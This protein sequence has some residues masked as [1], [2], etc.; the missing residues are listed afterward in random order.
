[1]WLPVYELQPLQIW[2]REWLWTNAL[3]S[4][5]N[6][7]E[8]LCGANP[9]EHGNAVGLWGIGNSC[10]WA[11]RCLDPIQELEETWERLQVASCIGTS[12][13]FVTYK[14]GSLHIHNTATW[15]MQT[16]QDRQHAP[17][18]S[19]KRASFSSENL[20]CSA[21]VR[22]GHKKLERIELWPPVMFLSKNSLLML[23]PL[24]YPL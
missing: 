4:K 9:L 22:S 6:F 10:K 17:E 16:L 19:L 20:S 1:M 15:Q 8:I 14:M 24:L 5:D 18:S 11:P 13:H 7:W 12:H 3:L 2:F 23:S 21:C